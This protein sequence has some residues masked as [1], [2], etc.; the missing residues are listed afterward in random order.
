MVKASDG[1]VWTAAKLTEILE[2]AADSGADGI[3]L[4]WV[5]EGLECCYI[6]GNT[7]VG[8]IITDAVVAENIID[9]IVTRARLRNKSSGTMSLRIAGQD[10]EIQVEEWDSFGESAFR[11]RFC[12][13]KGNPSR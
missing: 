6:S 8:S 9:A 5:P 13:S 1:Q 3:D 4:E 7:G 12:P 2:S 10:R 11:L